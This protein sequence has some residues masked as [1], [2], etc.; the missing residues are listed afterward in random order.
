[1]AWKIEPAPALDGHTVEWLE[2]GRVLLSRRNRIYR[3]SAPTAQRGLV[4]EIPAPAW[5]RASA[6][7]RLGQRLLRFMVY[8]LLPL[9]DG[10]IFVTFAKEVGLIADGRYRALPGMRRPCR[11]LRRGCAPTPDGGVVWG[12]YVGNEERGAITIY[13]YRAGAGAAEALYEFDPGQIRHVH[14]VYRDPYTDALWC[15]AG[16]L[17]GECR[18]LRTDDGFRTLETVG[19]GDETWRAV[20]LLFTADS[21]YYASDAEKRDNHVYRIDRA[22]GARTTLAKVDGPVYYTH[23]IDGHL[24]FATTAELCPSQTEPV[25][26]IWH[27]TPPGALTRLV[28]F[29]KD[30]GQRHLLAKLFMFGTLHFPRGPGLEGETYVTGVALREADDRT[31]RLRW[32]GSDA[33]G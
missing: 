4:A 14:G 33:P 24:L 30:L 18:I 15:V 9:P 21:L 22:S 13:R 12:E 8:N 3:A 28:S 1:M 7:I 31:F 23:A 2:P 27:L 6:R 11:V 5:K 10:T 17:P 26:S 32:R 16:D 29:E 20:S 19:E 25:A